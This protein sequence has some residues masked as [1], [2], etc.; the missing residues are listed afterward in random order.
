MRGIEMMLANG[1][2]AGS[3]PIPPPASEASGGE[4]RREQRERRGGGCLHS[5]GPPPASLWRASA[6]PSS[7]PSPPLR[8]GRDKSARIARRAYHA[9][10]THPRRDRP[11]DDGLQLL[12][13]LRGA[14]RGVSR[15]GDAPRVF[16]R[17]PQL[18]RQSL[19]RLRR[20]L[21]RL[22]VLAAAR[23][24]RQCPENVGDRPR[25]LLCRLCL[26]CRAVRP[27]R[28]QRRGH[29]LDR[30]AERRCLHLR[31]RRVE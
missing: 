27:V 17:R 22:P 25:Q 31:L 30:S 26:A 18:S 14:V 10:H 2:A 1:I 15:H 20:L 8:G 19:P 29:L 24:Q 13:L 11:P 9:R 23:V 3:A 28:A 7:A 21:R 6:L 12:P 5:K 16:R 4:G